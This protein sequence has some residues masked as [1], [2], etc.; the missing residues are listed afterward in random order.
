MLTELVGDWLSLI[1]GLLRLFLIQRLINTRLSLIVS[2]RGGIFRLRFVNQLAVNFDP[3]DEEQ[4]AFEACAG[5]ALLVAFIIGESVSPD[6]ADSE[7]DEHL[8]LAST[9]CW[10]RLTSDS[11]S[12]PTTLQSM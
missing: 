4:T 5:L 9:A 11:A 10:Q 1:H 8:L 3:A 7:G 6:V 2:G 12:A